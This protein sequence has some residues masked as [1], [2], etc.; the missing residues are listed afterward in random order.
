MTTKFTL[1]KP[2]SEYFH[3]TT[4]MKGFKRE[5]PTTGKIHMVL[6]NPSPPKYYI[7][8]KKTRRILGLSSSK[9]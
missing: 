8:D 7:V 6:N 5:V 9:R 4:R 1:V 2:K 3:Q